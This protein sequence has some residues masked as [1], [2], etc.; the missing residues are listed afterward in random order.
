[1]DVMDFR[2]IEEKWQ[3]RWKEIDLYKTPENPEKKFYLLE[4]YAYPSGDI[5][6]GHFRNY[7]IGDV[8][9]RYKSM[10]GYHILHPFGWDAFGLPAEQ[11]AINKHASPKQWTKNN[12]AQ[13][14]KTLQGVGISYDWEREITTCE[15]E[16]YKWTQWLFKKLYEH[17]L[18]YR[19]KAYVNWCPDCKTVLANEQ[20]IQGSWWRCE[21]AVT[22]NQTQQWFIKITS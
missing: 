1:M 15:P 14:K 2:E 20:V 18:C 17:G 5:H 6:I 3:K 11:A 16:Y 10:H 21:S 7:A 22:K 12:I 13:S 8:V 19:D 4:M 9:W